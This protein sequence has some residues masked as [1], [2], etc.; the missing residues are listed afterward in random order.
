MSD[1]TLETSEAPGSGGRRHARAADSGFDGREW[2]LRFAWWFVALGVIVSALI[3]SRVAHTRPGYDP[4]GWLVWGY[5]TI[6]GS[7]NLSGAP[8][9]KPLPLIA[10]APLALFGNQ[11]QLDLWMWLSL[12]ISFSG[13]VFAGRI[14]FKIVNRD[15]AHLYPAIVAALFAGFGMY[16]I[17][18]NINGTLD[19]YLHY[20]LSFQS[21]TMIVSLVL[22]AIDFHMQGRRRF[23]MALLMLAGLGR[24]EGWPVLFLYSAWCAWYKPQLRLFAAGVWAVIV[25]GWFGVPGITNGRPFVAYQLAQK[26]PRAI[27]GGKVL[28]TIDRF[29]ALNLW[30]VWLLALLALGVAVVVLG[31]RFRAL[32]L[33]RLL[34]AP[35][36]EG[37]AVWRSDQAFVVGL[38]F[39]VVLWVLVELAFALLGTPAVPRYMFEPAVVSVVLAGIG[40]GWLLV[41]IPQRVHVP[42]PAGTLVGAV[43][44]ACLIPGVH[45]R[46]SFEHRDLNG[47]AQRTHAFDQLAGFI[48]AMGGRDAVRSCGRPV[49]NIEFDSLLAW[50]LHM[51]VGNIGHQPQKEL[52]RHDVPVVLF[53]VLPNGWAAWPWHTYESKLTA[54]RRVKGIWTYPNDHTDGV[55]SV[56]DVAPH[57]SPLIPDTPTPG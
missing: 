2:M 46:A 38:A 48:H 49:A 37:L 6:H 36:A 55:Y 47:Q 12:T 14:A 19:P 9:W 8:S 33:R 7:L 26:S 44:L 52:H 22:A 25:F 17:Q 1:A 18:D 21:D 39:C 31:P 40:L 34:T 57:P 13:T 30:P 35:G 27:H 53:T 29:T 23:A 10:T 43:L 15:G 32:G 4:Y 41:E 5:Q 28:G 54:C 56:N 51:N 42:W 16:A 45:H 20:L 24:P 11:H 50:L 3:I